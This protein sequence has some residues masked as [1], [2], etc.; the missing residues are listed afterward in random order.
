[1]MKRGTSTMSDSGDAGEQL[2]LVGKWTIVNH[3]EFHCV[4]G[5]PA[6]PF[7]TAAMRRDG[8]SPGR[9]RT[10]TEEIHK[11]RRAARQVIIAP[12]GSAGAAICH[13]GC[14]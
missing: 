5:G 8:Q 1:M 6:L 14:A 11:S 10:T 4:E 7:A 9:L 12:V 2:A 3:V 13:G